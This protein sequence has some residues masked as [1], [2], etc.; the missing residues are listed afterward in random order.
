MFYWNV[1]NVY[2]FGCVTL[3]CN[4]NLNVCF[5]LSSYSCVSL[6]FR[7]I[8]IRF[9]WFCFSTVFN[10]FKGCLELFVDITY[11]NMKMNSISSEKK[12]AT[13]SIV[14][15]ITNSWRRRFG[16][17]LTN[18]SIRRSRNVRRTLR[19]E[20]PWPSPR[21]ACPSSTTLHKR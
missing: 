3:H 14:L 9:I 13:L 5:F 8:M 11:L 4:F 1:Q 7:N 16:M 18:F 21:Y 6:V 2:Q 12:I 20:L 15:N 19:P 17:N 10:I